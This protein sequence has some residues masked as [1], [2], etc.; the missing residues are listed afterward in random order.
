MAVKR[1]GILTGGGDCPG[2]N[3]VIRGVT[4]RAIDYGWEVIGFL[5]GW[6]GVINNMAMRKP[7]G[8]PEVE[9]ILW[10]GGTILGSS[11]TN[12]Y[13]L[14]KA[15]KQWHRT[16]DVD[17]VLATLK[18]RQIDALVAV[19]GDDTLSVAAKLFEEE[20]VKTVGV[21]KTMDNDV[22]ETDYTFGYDTAVTIAVEALERLRDT[23]RS[24]HRCIVF[25]VMGRHAGWVALAT[26]I[27]GAA[28]YVL[29]PEVPKIP[30]GASR[31]RA[32]KARQAELEAMVGHIN[33]LRRRGQQYAL[34]VVSEGFQL[35]EEETEGEGGVKVD[36]FGHAL[37]KERGVGEQV[38]RF[39]EERTGI[40]TR[41]V[42]IGH[43]QRGGAPTTFDRILSTRMGVKAADMVHEEQW[44]K[45]AALRGD[46]LVTA[47]IRKAVA[48]SK[49]VPDEWYE[50]ATVFWK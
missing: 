46:R 50:L 26:G 45:M 18:K 38:A 5:D 11:R 34:I 24:H 10:Q 44:G 33:R 32:N 14:D 7:L 48:K 17:R 39:V 4:M 47:D 21:P 19:G 40:E 23:A 36:A 31:E 13:K 25:E 30:K 41:A 9:D 15:T 16:D 43:I 27:A 28:D 29:I 6:R 35:P 49:T 42:A 1:V 3:G 22:S 2:L 12:P 8:I 37:L 20:K